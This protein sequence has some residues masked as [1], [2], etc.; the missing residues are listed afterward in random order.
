MPPAGLA[1]GQALQAV[2]LDV[3]P[4]AGV[5]DLSCRLKPPTTRST[6][7]SGTSVDAKVE[8]VKDEY[9]VVSLAQHG[10]GY[11]T[12]TGI[13][14]VQRAAPPVFKLGMVYHMSEMVTVLWHIQ[15]P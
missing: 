12:W 13:N 4:G 7:P 15:N 11:V 5:V 8:L 14:R 6:P 10:V 2:V 1:A 9:A 3:D